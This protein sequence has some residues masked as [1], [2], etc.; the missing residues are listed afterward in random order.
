MLTS[1][2]GK[3]PWQLVTPLGDVLGR[4]NNEVHLNGKMEHFLQS[5]SQDVSLKRRLKEWASIDFCNHE[6]EP[7]VMFP[8]KDNHQFFGLF[9]PACDDCLNRNSIIFSREASNTQLYSK[10]I[11][12]E[13]S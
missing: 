5:R 12:H 10:R 6:K 4:E 1:L 13:I 9:R 8:M 7:L 2:V 3:P 11:I